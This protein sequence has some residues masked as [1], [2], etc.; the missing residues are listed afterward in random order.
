[1]LPYFLNYIGI[2]GAAA[3]IVVHVADCH[4]VYIGAKDDEYHRGNGEDTQQCEH[5]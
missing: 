2:R 1:M 5:K 3:E 4:L